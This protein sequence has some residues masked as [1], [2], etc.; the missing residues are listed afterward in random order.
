[1]VEYK[2]GDRVVFF[3]ILLVY[4]GRVGIEGRVIFVIENIIF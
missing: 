4:I 1:M 2:N 3:G